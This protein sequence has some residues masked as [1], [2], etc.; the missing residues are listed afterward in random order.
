MSFVKLIKA[1]FATNYLEDLILTHIKTTYLGMACK[2]INL[3]TYLSPLIWN[4]Q[5][6]TILTL[7][8]RTDV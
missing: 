1:I 3:N 4:T 7:F 8:R 2:K 6:E 5:N